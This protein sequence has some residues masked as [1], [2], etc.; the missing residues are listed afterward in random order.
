MLNSLTSKILQ[1][2]FRSIYH[3]LENAHTASLF[4]SWK[5]ELAL[6]TCMPFNLLRLKDKQ[7]EGPLPT[8]KSISTF[9]QVCRFF[10]VSVLVAIV[11][12]TLAAALP[13]QLGGYIQSSCDVRVY[14]GG[15]RVH[16]N[17]IVPVLTPWFDWG[18]FLTLTEVGEDCGHYR[19]LSFG[20]GDRAFYTATPTWDDFRLSAALEALFRSSG[21]VLHV[22][23]YRAVPNNSRAYRVKSIDLSQT[24]Y[25]RLVQFIRSSFSR[26]SEGLPLRIQESHNPWGSFYVAEGQYSI[27]YT[28][29]DWTADGLQK[30]RVNTPLWSGL[31]PPVYR[32]AKS[33]C[34]A[35]NEGFRS[36]LS[37]E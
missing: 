10:A 15:D 3:L 6:Y 28:C 13:R 36:T 23:G 37:Q 20:W 5:K 27:L 35:P 22:Q 18:Q 7:S 19:Y 8:V 16:T 24:D 32:L 31:A 17:L 29:N 33:S 30:A 34:S 2:E 12:L 9:K 26:N 21:S 14:V 4:R 25:L 11:L 1:S